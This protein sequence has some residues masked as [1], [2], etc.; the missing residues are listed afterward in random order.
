MKGLQVKAK[1][2]WFLPV[3]Y[4]SFSKGKKKNLS[5]IHCKKEGASFDPQLKR[6]S[7]RVSNDANA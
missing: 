2:L 3:L 5:F 1:C 6:T 7:L 4:Q